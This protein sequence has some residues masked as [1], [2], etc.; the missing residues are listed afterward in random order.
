[1]VESDYAV[2]A[3][4]LGPRIDGLD[5]DPTPVPH[6]KYH[7]IRPDGDRTFCDR[8]VDPDL[9]LKGK[10]WGDYFPTLRCEECITALEG[11]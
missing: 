8:R 10:T 5:M 1:M 7:A 11:H 4:S 3:N 9:V 6:G 2:M